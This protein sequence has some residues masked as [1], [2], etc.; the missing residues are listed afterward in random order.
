[1]II[2]RQ[3]H[4]KIIKK[5]RRMWIYCWMGHVSD[6]VELSVGGFVFREICIVRRLVNVAMISFLIIS[7]FYYRFINVIDG[8]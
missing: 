2:I 6:F 5:K 4:V 1:M 8:G 7:Y 3:T